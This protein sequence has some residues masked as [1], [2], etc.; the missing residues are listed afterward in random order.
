MLQVIVPTKN[1]KRG[2]DVHGFLLLD[3]PVGITSNGIL[4]RVKRLFN[5]RKAGHTGSLDKMASGLLPVCFGEATKFSGYLLNADKQYRVTCKLGITTDTGD[6]AGTVKLKRSSAGINTKKLN[7]VLDGFHG[8]TWQVPPMYS[9]LKHEGTRL[10]QLAYQGISV[11]RK[12]RKIQIHK[13]ELLSFENDQF[14]IEVSCSKGT[15]IRTLVE[16]IGEQLGCGAH[17]MALRRTASGP[18]NETQMVSPDTLEHDAVNGLTALDGHLLEIDSVLQD[19]AVVKVVNSTAT[20]I[21]QGQ[22]VT[23]PHAPVEGL[24]RIYT[25][26]R[27]FLGIGEVL[28]DGR[29]TPRRLIRLT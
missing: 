21:Q 11:E 24:V 8:E 17:V 4:Q 6:A 1:K 25:E 10:Y 27:Q 7:H 18:F 3:K 19:L 15:Y 14:D 12:A 5:A 20:Y 29:I 22:A 23:I 26:D 28:N 2:R 9:A 16:D 13:I